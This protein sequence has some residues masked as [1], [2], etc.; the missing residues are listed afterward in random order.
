MIRLCACV[1]LILLCLPTVPRAAPP[2]TTVTVPATSD[3]S[4]AG[5]TDSVSGTEPVEISLPPGDNRVVTFA[6][7]SGTIA[8]ETNA[9]LHRADGVSKF[10]GVT[11]TDVE[12]TD[13]VSGIVH[14]ASSMFLAGVF[15]GDTDDHDLPERLEFDGRNDFEFVKPA[16]GQSFFIGDGRTV[17]GTKVQKFHVPNG[18]TRLY[19][20]FVDAYDQASSRPF[21]G[22][23][24][25]YGD[26][27][28]S[29]VVRLMVR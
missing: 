12:S 14:N 29:L 13:S 22:S 20:G 19:L 10:A 15:F 2:L 28:G 23:P 11:G 16:I 3:L 18:A 27:I 9:P 17:R 24:G 6:K 5:D 26:N 25:V 7:V 4:A 8:G 21:R 1:A